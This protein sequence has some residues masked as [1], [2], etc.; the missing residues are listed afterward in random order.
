MMLNRFFVLTFLLIIFIFSP[1]AAQDILTAVQFFDSISANY[2][3]IDDYEARISIITSEA[4]MEGVLFYKS[5]NLLRINFS[6]PEEQVIS[7]NNDILTL[8]IPD[9]NVIMEQ[10]L[11]RHSDATLAVMASK[12]GLELLKKG[13]SVAFLKGP[14]PVLLDEGSEEIVRKLNLVWRQTDEGYRQ[15]EMSITE[16]GMIRRMKGLTVN[17][18]TFQ[19]DFTEIRINQS[20]PLSR[21]DYEAPP[22]AYVMNNFLFEPEE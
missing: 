4:S 17:Y 11:Q 6:E 21:F 5:P 2:G 10:K 14:D 1:L 3:E 19:F 12:E 8:H 9:Q 13:Y 22:S 18:E 15:I 7:V 16:D 20:I